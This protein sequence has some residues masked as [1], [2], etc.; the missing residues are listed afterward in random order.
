MSNHTLSIKHINKSYSGRK[1]ISDASFL[2]KSGEIVGLLG[3]NGAGKTTCFYIT[4]GLI[5]ANSG[6]VFLNDKKEEK[7]LVVD[8]LLE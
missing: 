4:C 8:D 2:I 1:V 3:P 6:E 5:R 7:V